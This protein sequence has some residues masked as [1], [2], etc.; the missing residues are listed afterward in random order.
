M[1][2][3]THLKRILI[4]VTACI[5]LAC[6][7]HAASGG[8]EPE[9]EPLGC[10]LG[11]KVF[12]EFFPDA[13]ELRTVAFLTPYGTLNSNIV[14]GEDLAP[15]AATGAMELA[16]RLGE[17]LIAVNSSAMTEHVSLLANQTPE[18]YLQEKT[19]LLCGGPEV[20]SL[21]KRLVDSGASKVD[22]SAEKTGK[23][24]VVPN[25]FGGNGTAVIMA[26]ADATATYN[27]TTA[28]AGFFAHLAGATMIESWM[29]YADQ[30]LQR[31]EVQ[32]AAKS[33]ER[34]VCGLRIDGASNFHA[35][36]KNFNDAFPELLAEEASQA[37]EL[38]KA[39]LAS[40][41]PEEADKEFRELAKKC[42]Y[43][44]QRYLSYDRM[45][46]NRVQYNY[47]QYPGHRLET[48]WDSVDKDPS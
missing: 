40:P 17:F 48:E 33:F 1:K 27:A 46:T 14:L 7:V 16:E 41:S 8:D 26:G 23:I 37:Q 5:L 42:V 4:V 6:G 13:V 21:V 47:S 11:G 25:A 10:H 29:L 38:H 39:L 22:W 45:S 9:R 36:I 3:K 2:H 24:E 44:H 12:Q 20:N 18:K 28:L 19:M 15:L 30:Q 31:G 32:G 34:I 43:C 35:P